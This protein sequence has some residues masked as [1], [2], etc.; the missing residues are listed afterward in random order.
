[1]RVYAG[2]CR[3]LIINVPPRY[4]K[5]ELVKQFVAWGLGQYPDSEFIYASYSARLAALSSYSI[6]QELSLPEFDATFGVQLADDSTA[7]DEWRT[8]GGGICYAVG[9]GGTITGYGAGKMR[10]GFGGALII[11]DPIKA[12]EAGSQAVRESCIDW[13]QSTVESRLNSPDTPIIV[14]MQ[15][16]HVNDLA[17]FLL[18]G[19]SGETWEHL[20]LPAINAD[21]SALWPEKHSIDD[22]G[23]MREANP[24]HFA[25]QYMQDPVPR[26][27]GEIKPDRMPIIDAVPA[28]TR[29][30]RGWD[31]AATEA[32]VGSDPDWT[33]GALLGVMPD[34]RWVIAD[35]VRLR[36]SS[37]EVRATIYNASRRDGESVTQSLPQDPGQAGK[38]QSADLVRML[39]PYNAH[40]TPET[41]S[42]QTRADP[43]TAQINV[44]N[45][46]MVR[47]PWNDAVINEMRAFPSG[48]SH[49]DIIDACSRAFGEL[50]S[51]DLM[52]AFLDGSAHV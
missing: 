11:D 9:V 34:G 44:G 45:V 32:R 30:V 6:R 42:K 1:M 48:A 16:L 12:A 2:E 52:S 28:G 18:G 51:G 25:A 17:G 39:A 47:A 33:V 49:D 19:G 35:I 38:S 7:R 41:G 13:Y 10:P 26:E 20:C 5:T 50:T 46:C 21:G 27:G 40:A 24:Y 29:L 37:D 23:R 43:L 15:R 36:G 22:L 31:L 3:R 8:D 14:I 4:S